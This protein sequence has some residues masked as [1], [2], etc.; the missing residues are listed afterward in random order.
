M[1]I[2]IPLQKQ[3]L[4]DPIDD[5]IDLTFLRLNFYYI[6]FWIWFILQTGREALRIS[7]SL[8]LITFR[9][10][11][12]LLHIFPSCHHFSIKTL[13]NLISVLQCSVNRQMLRMARQ[14][15]EENP[16]FSQESIGNFTLK[17]FLDVKAIIRNSH[18]SM[19]R[20][21]QKTRNL[22]NRTTQYNTTPR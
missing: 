20:I 13:K 1:T 18:C 2:P 9:C 16:N 8:T 19:C 22:I 5:F 14:L 3:S 17:S 11:Y 12:L 15:I 10:I 21:K 7:R 4:K 6:F